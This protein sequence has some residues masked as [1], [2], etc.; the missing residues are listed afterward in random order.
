M[1]EI[2]AGVWMK[3]QKNVDHGRVQ[4]P[5][6]QCTPFCIGLLFVCRLLLDIPTIL[7]FSRPFVKACFLVAFFMSMIILVPDW[8]IEKVWSEAAKDKDLV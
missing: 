5:S 3:R 8:L 7:A 2:A 4:S 1:L 6:P